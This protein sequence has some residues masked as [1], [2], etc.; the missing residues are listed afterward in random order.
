MKTILQKLQEA[1]VLSENEQAVSV[2]QVIDLLKKVEKEKSSK[3]PMKEEFAALI[4]TNKY[5]L[6]ATSRSLH[7]ATKVAHVFANLILL[8]YLFF[9]IINF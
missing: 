5:F 1:S 3:K 4:P 8:T 6:I 2:I 9:L 7:D